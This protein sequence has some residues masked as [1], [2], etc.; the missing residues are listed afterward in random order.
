MFGFTTA[1]LAS[2]GRWCLTII[3]MLAVSHGWATQ[4]QAN[5]ISG[6]MIVIGGAILA[7]APEVYS[8]Y[9]KRRQGIIS[10]AAALP[11]VKVI[12]PQTEADSGAHANNND[13]VGPAQATAAAA[14]VASGRAA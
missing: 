11:N 10:Q 3:G 12:V 4:D 8:I 7:A 14:E 2:A 6:D 13:V 1:Q 5:M 9:I